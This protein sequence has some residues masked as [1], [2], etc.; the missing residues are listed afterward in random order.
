M[1][2]G[3]LK[4]GCMAGLVV[5]LVMA[6]NNVVNASPRMS[7]GNDAVQQS[8][9]RSLITG[10][11]DE[12]RLVTLGGNTRPEANAKNDRGALPEGYRLDDMMLLLQRAPEQEQALDEFIDQLHDKSSPNFHKWLNATEFGERF[13]V[14]QQDIAAISGWLKSHGFA[15][16]GVYANR[17]VID[18]SGTAGQIR[19]AFHT[20]MH[21]LSVKGVAHI[22]NMSDPQIPEALAAAVKGVVSLNDFRP[23]QMKRMK[24]PGHPFGFGSR[25]DFTF[26]PNCGFL[27]SLRDSTTNCEALMP[28]DLE[29]IYNINPLLSAGITGKGQTIVVIED[30]DPYSL[31]DWN[32]FRK[33]AG[34][35]RAYPYGSVAT[36]HPTGAATCT[37]EPDQSDTTDDEVA[38]DMEWASAAAPNAAIQVAVC[39]DSGATF[40]GLIAIE[41]IVNG[42]GP[43]PGTVSISYGE[44]ESTNG[45]T[46][47]AMY[48]RRIRPARPRVFRS[49][50]PP[51]TKALAVRTPMA[52][53]APKA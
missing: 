24:K 27:T 19:Q 3:A 12:T 10:E 20:E 4:V 1:S 36:T 29:T 30:E 17:M 52:L 43:Y 22:S 53:I 28:Q 42:A 41:N 45:A 37:D 33:V 9:V 11:I 7:A 40:G 18:F 35:A 44:S 23:H 8:P 31:G 32:Y 16:H 25:P 2:K 46:Q 21:N 34:L 6:A 50:C 49:S 5:L 51:V 26:G 39:K 47:N 13:G 48:T 38:I 15:V 14:G